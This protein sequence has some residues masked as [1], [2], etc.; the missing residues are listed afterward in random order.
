[1]G[2][3]GALAQG[4]AGGLGSA[5]IVLGYAWMLR[6]LALPDHMLREE[7]APLVTALVGLAMVA[8]VVAAWG[9]ARPTRKEGPDRVWP[10][11]AVGL[12]AWFWVLPWLPLADWT[13]PWA[14]F[15]VSPSETHRLWH[16]MVSP[17]LFAALSLGVGIA[18]L[19]RAR[20]SGGRWVAG[21]M[22]LPPPAG[23]AV[24]LR[25]ALRFS[26]A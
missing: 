20:T 5:A 26:A 17:P 23:G 24:L 22:P 21:A 3:R 14:E 9:P 1:M 13:S 7:D 18:T 15:V 2:V 11:L 4:I 12:A 19:R 25:R 10:A 8:T 6:G 16:L